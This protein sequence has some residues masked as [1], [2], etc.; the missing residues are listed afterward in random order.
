[1]ITLGASYLVRYRIILW[2][3][4]FG[5]KNQRTHKTKDYGGRNPCAR[6][7]K[8][9]R[10]NANKSVFFSLSHGTV[11]QGIPKTRNR[12]GCS[13]SCEINERLVKP[14]TVEN[15]SRYHEGT[16]GMSGC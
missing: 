7:F 14:K 1:M 12:D 3:L 16:H 11:N 8:N 6:D 13:G 9:A 4:P 2:N 10:N 15:R 5:F